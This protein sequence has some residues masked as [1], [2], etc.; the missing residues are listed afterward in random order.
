M[1]AAGIAMID[2]EGTVRVASDIARELAAKR[3]CS[4]RRAA[5]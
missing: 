3:A 4:S 5:G 2:G 1:R